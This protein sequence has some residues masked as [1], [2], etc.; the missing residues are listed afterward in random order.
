MGPMSSSLPTNSVNRGQA[1]A[2]KDGLDASNKG[3]ASGQDF[4]SGAGPSPAGKVLV[5]KRR[6]RT[7]DDPATSTTLTGA[8]LLFCA[9][10]DPFAPTGTFGALSASLVMATG[11]SGYVPDSRC[12]FGVVLTAHW[13][14]A[15][16]WRPVVRRRTDSGARVLLGERLL[17]LL[18]RPML[19]STLTARPQRSKPALSNRCVR[20]CAPNPNRT[21]TTRSTA[22]RQGV[23]FQ[24]RRRAAT[25]A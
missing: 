1:S 4:A 5:S 15:A 7:R 19:T 10:F 2:P 13:K 11:R 14:D 18:Q 9:V 24:L 12:L 25:M 22:S 23:I 17:Q 20:N 3:S 6:Q 21:A 16:T 8:H